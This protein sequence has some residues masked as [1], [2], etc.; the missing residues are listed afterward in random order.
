MKKN[1]FLDFIKEYYYKNVIKKWWW[2]I[3]SYTPEFFKGKLLLLPLPLSY[4]DFIKTF[5]DW[6]SSWWLIIII[7][8]LFLIHIKVIYSLQD[9]TSNTKGLDTGLPDSY[10]DIL[11]EID[12]KMPNLSIQTNKNLIQAFKKLNTN[13]VKPI[14]IKHYIAYQLIKNELDKLYKSASPRLIITPKSSA[15]KVKLYNDYFILEA[16]HVQLHN[17]GN[18]PSFVEVKDLIDGINEDIYVLLLEIKL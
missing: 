3:F 12:S 10:Q 5:L 16:W 17:N 9:N 11:D 13:N 1:N 18:I 2:L 6:Y 14:I 7:V 15:I 4:S 8:A